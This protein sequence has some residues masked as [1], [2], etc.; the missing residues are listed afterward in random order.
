M[1]TVHSHALAALSLAAAGFALYA[2][3]PWRPAL[4]EEAILTVYSSSLTSMQLTAAT[5]KQNVLPI[6]LQLR[7]RGVIK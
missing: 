5:D 1:Q 7:I 2:A 3:V 4:T 6:T